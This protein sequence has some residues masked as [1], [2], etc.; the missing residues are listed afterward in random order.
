MSTSN[1]LLYSA[2]VLGA[3]AA[4]LG[5]FGKLAWAYA[6]LFVYVVLFILGVLL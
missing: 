4:A 5:I 3:L 6:A 1:A 2:M